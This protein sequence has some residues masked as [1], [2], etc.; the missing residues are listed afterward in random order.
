MSALRDTRA[1]WR[2]RFSRRQVIQAGV[3][4]GV[5]AIA[6]TA[7]GTGVHKPSPTRAAE[8]AVEPALGG[9]MVRPLSG[10]YYGG[11]TTLDPYGDSSFRSWPPAN[12]HFSRL[13]Q[14]V[15]AGEGIDSGNFAQFEN[16]LA[17]SMPEMPDAATY[18]FNIREDARWH[19]VEPLDGRTVTTWDIWESYVRFR[20]VAENAQDWNRVVS[21]ATVNPWQNTIQ[22][23]LREPYAPFLTLAGSSHHLWIIPPE[24]VEDGSVATRPVGSGPWI[25]ES[26]ESDEVMNWRRNPDWHRSRDFVSGGVSSQRGGYL[27]L[28]GLEPQLF[29]LVDQIQAIVNPGDTDTRLDGLSEGTLDLAGI[30]TFE[31]H[32]ARAD[33]TQIEDDGFVFTTSNVPAGFYFN[34]S[35]PPWNDVRVRQA[36]SLALDRDAVLDAVDPTGHGHWLGRIAQTEPY[37]LDPRDLAEFGRE[38]YGEESGLLFHRDLAKARALLDAAGYSDGLQATLH[39]TDAYGGVVGPVRDACVASVAEGG[40]DLQLSFKS[41]Y[42]YLATTFRGNFPDQWDGESSDLAI[43]PLFNGG[44]D[45]DDT[46]RTV[47]DR[48]SERHS[49]GSPGRHPNGISD[50]QGRDTGGHAGAWTH[51]NSAFGGGPDSDEHMHQMFTTQRGMLD[52]DERL[53]YIQDIQRYL[54]TKMY[55]VPHV[56]TPGVTAF[57]PWVKQIDPRSGRV[58]VN[59]DQRIWPKSSWAWASETDPFLF[60]DRGQR[61]GHIARSL[62]STPNLDAVMASTSPGEH[63]EWL[64]L[65]TATASSILPQLSGVRAIWKWTGK[66]W[67]PYGLVRDGRLAPGARDFEIRHGD[68]LYL[69]G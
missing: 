17:A 26:Y 39:T 69:S 7:V 14:R 15:S 35:I 53:A 19:N 9:Q 28:T 47:Y 41:Y 22:F 57:N 20:E 52:F 16:D 36:L 63:S 10:A 59:P 44:L 30:H 58:I 62:R 46:L 11:V 31:Y 49:W 56:A 8:S 27:G 48:R 34:F 51:E 29:P 42:E 65:Q 61:L 68:A 3:R 6:L 32:S 38:F 45:P 21:E 23:D 40:F 24:I 54:A 43:G 25:F 66:Q 55:I 60:I 13:I 12:F 1:I 67:I 37:A 4:A 5:G 18:V 50:V 2:R 33:A 64:S